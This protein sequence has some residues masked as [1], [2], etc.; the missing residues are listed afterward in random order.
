MFSRKALELRFVKKNAANQTVVE[1]PQPKRPLTEYITI[2]KDVVKTVAVTG[3]TLYAG[4]KL[5][6]TAAEIALIAAKAK[7]K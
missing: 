4:K 5:L 7:L 3:G 6:D 2:G 1:L